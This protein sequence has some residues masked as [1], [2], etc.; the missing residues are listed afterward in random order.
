MKLLEE[1]NVVVSP[2]RGFGETGEGFLRLAL[3]ENAQRLRQA[4]RQIAR[5]LRPDYASSSAS[6]ANRRPAESHVATMMAEP[7]S[8]RL[9]RAVDA[10]LGR[11]SDSPGEGGWWCCRSAWWRRLHGIDPPEDH[12]A[13]AGLQDAR[14][15]QAE[16]LAE[17]V[18]TL[19]GD[20]HRAVIEVA[21]AL[22]LFL[23]PFEELDR[24]ALAGQDDRLHGVGQVVQ[25]DDLD[26]LQTG[27]LVEV[28]VVGDNLAA[29]MLGQHDQPLVDLAD[30]RELGD[31][32]VMDPDLDTGR[33]LKPVEDVEPAAPAVATELVGT[34]RDALQLLE[35][36]PRDHQLLID[37][38]RLGDVGDPP[39][40]HDRGV[41]QQRAR[42]LDLLRELDVGMMK[43]K[44]SFVCSSV[45]IDR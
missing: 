23:A 4:V 40:D 25:V 16:R 35:H 33:L 10:A 12:P 41:E 20:D 26:A 7:G 39:V 21:D 13:G 3:V 19:L 42:A 28:V 45:E 44:S 17:V 14:D 22:S 30:A 18:G 31:I 32:A 27:D 38:A 2:G 11:D 36:E 37:D 5:C 24:Q 29:E 1:A 43:R 8:D 15:R 6:A 34:V 9:T